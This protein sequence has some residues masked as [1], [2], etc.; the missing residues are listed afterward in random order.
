MRTGQEADFAADWADVFRATTVGT[1]AVENH[2]A[3]NMFFES[4]ECFLDFRD[5][6]WIRF[7]VWNQSGN[8]LLLDNIH[9]GVTLVLANDLLDLAKFCAEWAD[10]LDCQRREFIRCRNGLGH[11]TGGQKVVLKCVQFLVVLV[12]QKDGFEHLGFRQFFAETF[13]HRH[14]GAGAGHDKVEVTLGHFLDCR[15]DHKF[16]IDSSQTHAGKW[17]VEWS[18]G[19]Q[20]GC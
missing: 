18:L 1:V 16:A 3:N 15:E 4:V 10:H 2:G 11:A 17:A 12:G 5:A 13:D 19:E 14:F 7:S 20:E 6:C 8:R 9:S